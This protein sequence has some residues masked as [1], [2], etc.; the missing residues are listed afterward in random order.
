MSRR[1]RRP[2]RRSRPALKARHSR[3]RPSSAC[4]H[5]LQELVR[6]TRDSAGPGFP[7]APIKSLAPADESAKVS[8]QASSAIEEVT[9]TMHEMSINVQKRREEHAGPG[10]QR[11]GN[12]RFHR[13]NGHFHSARRR[14]TPRFC[15]ISPTAPAEEVV[16][17]IQTMEKATDGLNRTNQAIQSSA[18]I[19]NILGPPRPMTSARLSK[20]STTSA[21]TDQSARTQTQ[22]SRAARAG[23]HGLGFAVVAD[24]VRKLAEKSTQS[25]QGNCR[26][27]PEHPARGP[28]R[29]S[30]TWS[31]GTRIVEEGLTLGQRSRFR[32][33]Q[34]F[35][36]GHRSLQVS[37][38]KSGL[39][40][41][42]SPWALRKS[43]RATSRLT[44]ITP[45]NQF[46]PSKNRLPAP[47]PLSAPWTR[48][49]S[50][51]Q[52]SASSFHRSFSAAAEQNAQAVPQLARR[53][54]QICSGPLY[55]QATAPRGNP[56][57][58]R[59]PRF[60]SRTA[61]RELEYAGQARS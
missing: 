24:E 7:P 57:A 60:G 11:R 32:A 12:L 29:P 35:Q 49:A 26:P 31:A 27:Y 8:V 58:S 1:R 39:P 2:D 37:P 44:E 51:W 38:R 50:W 41:T 36:C 54:G 16:S 19:I 4:P 40:P 53:H 28:A 59:R 6:T 18:E 10:F 42:N 3:E 15:W 13:S 34:D 55:P 23:E 21:E 17:G 48:C 46:P 14:Y 5:G 30:K 61:T 47:R 25:H 43:P 33:A 20:S 56:T 52:Q 45:G 9:S 22:P